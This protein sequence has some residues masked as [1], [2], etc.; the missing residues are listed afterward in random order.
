MVLVTTDGAASFTGNKNRMKK[1]NEEFL[2]IL[3]RQS[4]YDQKEDHISETN[5]CEVLY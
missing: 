3:M 1:I 2:L 4:I 5:S